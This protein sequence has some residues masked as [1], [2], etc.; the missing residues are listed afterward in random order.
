LQCSSAVQ[1]LCESLV[2]LLT[3]LVAERAETLA[4]SSFLLLL[5]CCASLFSGSH[6][7]WHL[8]GGHVDVDVVSAPVP[9][10]GSSVLLGCS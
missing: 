1:R 10:R 3:H 7:V 4:L 2:S 8:N 6:R 5:V 9:S